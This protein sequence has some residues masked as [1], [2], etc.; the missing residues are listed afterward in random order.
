MKW[1]GA[2][3]LALLLLY[4]LALGYL[5]LFQR[6]ILF[7]PTHERQ[8]KEGF[9]LEIPEGKVRV[10]RR[11]PGRGK[12]LIY[13]P[14]NSE[15]WWEDPDDLA[16][17][18]PEHTIYFPHYPGY[19]ASGGNPSQDAF[20]AMAE[21]LYDRIAPEHR[22]VDLIGRS[23]GSGVA[24]HLAARRPVRRIVLITSYDSIASLGAERYPLFPVRTIVKDPFESTRYASELTAPVLILLAEEDRVIPRTHSQNLIRFF[25][26]TEPKV[27]TLPRTDHGDII[28][29][30]EYPKLLRDFLEKK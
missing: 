25:R 19:G 1:W 17:L 7:H 8:A 5:Y 4:L 2:A 23:L 3:L 18:L 29:S 10:E 22:A 13:F 15:H 27:I 30:P 14:G 24:L 6:K 28:E 20:F 12:A 9:Y 16:R 26:K 11:N 21:T